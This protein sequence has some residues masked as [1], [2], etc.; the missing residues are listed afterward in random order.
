MRLSW[1]EQ[2]RADRRAEYVRLTNWHHHFTL[3]PTWI[4][5]DDCHWLEWVERK[6]TFYG[7]SYGYSYIGAEYRAPTSTESRK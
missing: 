6:L 3:L 7:G 5:D 4:A 1:F 2:S